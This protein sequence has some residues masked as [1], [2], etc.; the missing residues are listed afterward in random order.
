M[1]HKS[2]AELIRNTRNSARFFVEN[3]QLGWITLLAIFVWGIYGYDHMPKRKD[4]EIPVRTA[5]IICP[6]PGASAEQ[7]EQLVTRRIENKVA[8]N[9]NLGTSTPGGDYAIESLSLEGVSEVEIQL[10]TNVT[11]VQK[12]FSDINIKLKSINDL[13]EGAGPIEFSDDFGETAALM[14]TV[15]SPKEDPVT[16]SLRADAIRRAIVRA[17]SGLSPAEAASATSV[18]AAF[19]LSINPQVY[20]RLRDAAIHSLKDRDLIR[21]VRLFEGPGFIGFDTSV[22][23][24]EHSLDAAL[25][26]LIQDRFGSSSFDPDAWPPVVIKDPAETESKLAAVA[27]AKYT[28]RQLDRFTDL[29]ERTLETVPQ[30]SKV[31][32]RGVQSEE[33]VLEYSQQRLAAYGLQPDEIQKILSAR[34]ITSYGG[35]MQVEGT[36]LAVHPSGRFRDVSQIGGVIVGKSPTG[37]PIYLR[38]LADISRS[39]QSPARYLNF[40]TARD[41]NGD[42]RTYRAVTLAVY[43]RSGEQIGTFGAAVNRA[44]AGVQAQLPEGLIIARTSDQPRQVK[45][46]ISIFMDSLY[47]AIVLVVIVAFIG[48]GESRSA[49]LMALSIPLT[50]AMTF[51]MAHLLRIDLQQVSIA[52]L[53]IALGLLVDDPV[54]AGDAIKRELS[55]GRPRILAAWLG[56][57]KLARAILFATITNIVA[58]LPFLLLTGNTGQFLYSLPIVMTCALVASRIVSMTMIP[59]LGYYLLRPPAKP[60]LSIKERRQRGLTGFYYRVGVFSIEHRWAVFAGSIAFLGLG[61]FFRT[62]LKTAFFPDDLQYLSYIDLRLPNSATLLD[63]EQ[64]GRRASQI[65]QETTEQFARGKAL[66]NHAPQRVLESITMLSAAA[67]RASGFRFRRSR[68]S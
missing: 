65:I 52:S 20:A 9:S 1:A 59:M 42:W 40:Y 37:A 5:M 54:V 32:R 45:E 18:V 25:S 10:A 30:V 44:L 31:K 7:V 50:L 13:P 43:M 17:R 41:A 22:D 62:Q 60:A 55:E 61:V 35:A 39:Y 23:L 66:S 53:I 11:D 21:D 49:V 56:P 29:I 67:V 14:I 63:T 6:W 68:R 47:E 16:I 12:V 2:D 28:Y 64:T 34:N 36:Q 15:A 57:T 24:D 26:Q 8:E 51:G 3:R 33:I 19:P 4:P 27:G 38:D 58:Y 46:Q 48:F